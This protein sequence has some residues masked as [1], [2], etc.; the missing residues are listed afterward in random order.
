MQDQLNN[1][2]LLDQATAALRDVPV[3]QGPPEDLIAKTLERLAAESESDRSP[4]NWKI[5]IMKHRPL[6][7]AAVVTIVS[8]VALLWFISRPSNLA[9]GAVIEKVRTISA[10][11][12]K[13]SGK[14]QLPNLPIQDVV[15]EVTVAEP[16][17][18]REIINKEHLVM[19]IDMSAGKQMMLD[20]KRKSAMFLDMGKNVSPQ[21]AN[22]NVLDHFKKFDPK[23]F[24]PVGEKMI[25]QKKVTGFKNESATG[26]QTVWVD[27][28]TQLPI[29]METKYSGPMFPTM[30][31]AMTDFDWNPQIDDSTFSLT[32]PE[33]YKS[34]TMSMDMSSL[35]EKDLTDGLHQLAEYND[36]AFPDSL[37]M[38][39]MMQAIKKH[40]EHMPKPDHA[41]PA[42]V[43]AMRKAQMAEIMPVLRAMTF[44]AKQTDTHYAGKGAKLNEANRPIVWYRP[45]DAKQYR[46][47]DAALNV[48]DVDADHLPQIPSEPVGMGM[49][50]GLGTTQPVK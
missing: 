37:G 6:T 12:F 1:D 48:T 44:L 34:D 50:M 11:S 4:F 39:G 32:P 43:D 9:F 3:S 28:D 40:I 30:D 22:V 33:G 16:F 24:K 25:E 14:V 19:V 27:P 15:A 13:M 46:L 17:K 8:A 21:M 29:Q 49:G 47:I 23:D 41:A 38:M 42:D 45:T 5:F 10:V 20:P 31:V 35:S 7:A 36:G 26:T 2:D 18:M